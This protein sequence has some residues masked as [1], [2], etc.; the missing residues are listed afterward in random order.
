MR[1]K[2]TGEKEGTSNW[3]V[4]VFKIIAVNEEHGQ[5]YYRVEGMDRDYKRA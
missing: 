2:K 3:S 5:N 1:K 4:K